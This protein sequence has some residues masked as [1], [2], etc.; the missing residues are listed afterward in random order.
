MVFSSDLSAG[1]SSRQHE[2]FRHAMDSLSSIPSVCRHAHTCQLMP[3]APCADGRSKPEML[4]L[5]G[6]AVYIPEPAA[7]PGAARKGKE[8]K[9]MAITI[10]ERDFNG[11][12]LFHFALCYQKPVL[13]E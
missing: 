9:C 2:Q 4:T 1:N 7:V 5:L 10:S 3:D 8:V 12:P 11:M 6:M 13:L